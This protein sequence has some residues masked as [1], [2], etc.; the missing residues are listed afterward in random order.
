MENVIQYDIIEITL[1]SG[2]TLIGSFHS[3]IDD[4]I[5]IYVP[6]KI[7]YI[8]IKETQTIKRIKQSSDYD[9]SKVAQF[10]KHS[11]Y[12]YTKRYALQDKLHM[13]FDNDTFADATII[14]IEDDCLILELEDKEKLYINFNYKKELPIGITQISR[15]KQEDEEDVNETDQELI[16]YNIDESK[17]Q[18]TLNIQINSI[19]QYLTFTKKY[20]GE[21][22][23]QRYKE[24]MLTFPYGQPLV[25]DQTKFKWV[26]PITNATVQLYN[27]QKNMQFKKSL[28]NS[29][30]CYKNLELTNKDKQYNS[31]QKFIHSI[32]RVF[33]D[34]YPLSSIQTYLFPTSNIMMFQHLK[35][36]KEDDI[37]W[38]P[39]I[40]HWSE[41]TTDELLP[42][43]GY[44][45]L[46]PTSITFSKLYLPE[47]GL[48]QKVQ[49]NL[50]SHLHL[51]NIKCE[52][53]FKFKEFQNYADSIPTIQ[54]LM[55][56]FTYYSFHDFIKQ[57]EP[58]LIYPNHLD[59][60]TIATIQSH[61]SKNKKVFLSHKQTNTYLSLPTQTHKLYEKTYISTSELYFHALAQD[62]GNVFI[63]STI[64]PSD[65]LKQE[66]PKPSKDESKFVLNPPEPMCEIKQDCNTNTEKQLSN[67]LL[68]SY[69][70]SNVTVLN[71]ENVS[72]LKRKQKYNEYQQLKYNI[73]FNKV[74]SDLHSERP[75]QSYELFY[76]ILSFPLK[77]RYTALLQFITKYTKPNDKNPN[78][79]H[80]SSTDIPL[81][82]VILKTL[83]ESY[84]STTLE[85]YY[86]VLYAYCTASP[87]VYIED[88]FYKD[89]N[90]SISLAPILKASSY[91]ELA[92]SSELDK[93]VQYQT[94]YTKEQ[95]QFMNILST[96]CTVLMQQPKLTSLDTIFINDAIVSKPKKIILY[97]L[98]YIHHIKMQHSC[99][100][101]AQE[102]VKSIG[103]LEK[104]DASLLQEIGKKIVVS[105]IKR[106]CTYID[107]KYKV[108]TKKVIVKEHKEW[109]T[110]MPSS[111]STYPVIEAIKTQIQKTV[112]IH[113]M[114]DEIKRVNHVLIDF[115]FKD[116][117]FPHP[118][119]QLFSAYVNKFNTP[120]YLPLE[121]SFDIIKPLLFRDMIDR[122]V[123]L[124]V[125]YKTQYDIRD[126]QELQKSF[127]K[128][129]SKMNFHKVF[130]QYP[131]I[132][133]ANFIKTILQFYGKICTNIDF[134]TTLYESAIPITHTDLI[135][136]SHF[137]SITTQIRNY[138]K[139]PPINGDSLTPLWLELSANETIQHIL[140]ELKQ[141]L[142]HENM[143]VI[144]FF[145]LLQIFKEIDLIKKKGRDDT[146]LKYISK[147]FNSELD[148]PDYAD[149][150]KKMTVRQSLERKTVVNRSK[151][152]S[153]TEKL[154]TSIQT[155]LNTSTKYNVPQFT[156]RLNE[157]QLFQGVG[158]INKDAEADAGDDG[159]LEDNNT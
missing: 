30:M 121:F 103:L 2:T 154:L 10:F 38:L 148:I 140:E 48:M 50:L 40:Q 137:E 28:A 7:E 120:D 9:V 102:I 134:Y 15:N 56:S 131:S 132:Y 133:I 79:L 142:N 21:V 37:N 42:I 105:E 62:Y 81:V 6:S 71:H 59:Y 147:K 51:F 87:Q 129:I 152:L 119:K 12:I 156:S 125:Q 36:S 153:E 5:I 116:V 82:P 63:S 128:H 8:P 31:I 55:T 60:D 57:L 99:E 127:A 108:T 122:D 85:E 100:T 66:P 32:F 58:Y 106:I 117:A 34:D 80:C 67:Y 158:L 61:I 53:N 27:L 109:K 115:S 126:L 14:E 24:L 112:P 70:S 91:D 20:N 150:K 104:H 4:E 45:S 52:P 141:P 35:G 77:K 145:Y 23:A 47:T 96:L 86:N 157:A 33:T 46:P 101:I 114:G 69:H 39:K 74:Q 22:F 107:E 98:I 89:K 68:T 118:H 110:F 19:L 3:M 143:N 76:Q 124:N 144:L 95:Q 83:A 75:P 44:T 54:S 111:V 93:D 130:E 41:Y 151:Q 97:F 113:H 11:S 73:K 146:V 13:V 1:K 29:L 25:P 139:D 135:A 84:L 49:F 149:L 26:Y 92:Q 123:D 16:S 94:I 18:Y 64:K 43:T 65:P 78:M 72:F 138:Y 159:N 17:C 155:N 136:R 90:T 88:G